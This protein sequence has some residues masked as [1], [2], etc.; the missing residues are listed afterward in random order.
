VWNTTPVAGGT[1]A[2]FTGSCPSTQLC[3]GLGQG[4]ANVSDLLLTT[5]PAA[6][7]PWTT[8]YVDHPVPLSDDLTERYPY[9]PL[10][11]GVTD[12]SCP[13]TSLCV[14]TDGVGRVIVGEAIH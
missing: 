1:P 5:A 13:S 8:T 7:G 3:V 4:T 10:P 6:G 9:N 11:L 12:L 14:A 2:I